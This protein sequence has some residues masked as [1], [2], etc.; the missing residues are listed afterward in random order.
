MRRP[1]AGLRQGGQGRSARHGAARERPNG[2]R[3]KQRRKR[4]LEEKS[5]DRLE[6]RGLAPKAQASKKKTDNVGFMKMLKYV[7]RKT[8][9]T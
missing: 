7:H 3:R 1:E 6:I 4:H 5:D 9:S 2:V 8:P